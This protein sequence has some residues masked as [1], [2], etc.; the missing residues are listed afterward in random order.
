[1]GRPAPAG[2]RPPPARVRAGVPDHRAGPV[3]RQGE[4]PARVPPRRRGRQAARPGTGAHGCRN[5]HVPA[6]LLA[7]GEAAAARELARLVALFGADSVAVELTQHGHPGD[8]E[9][10]DALAALA[11]RFGLPWPNG[12]SPARR[13]AC[14]W[15]GTSTP[16][17]ISPPWRGTSTWSCRATLK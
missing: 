15:T 5:G 17:G 11:R 7:E 2:A 14:P 16:R 10:N 13:A 3:G 8:D 6:A 9:R 4:G 1:P 12:C